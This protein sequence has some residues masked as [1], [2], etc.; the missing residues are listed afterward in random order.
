MR[1]TLKQI[2][3]ALKLLEESTKPLSEEE[4]AQKRHDGAKKIADAAEEKGGPAML[5]YHHFKVK[6]PYYREAAKG[7]FDFAK[8]EKEYKELCEKLHGSEYSKLTQTQFQE[9]VGRI[10]VLGELLINNE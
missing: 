5:T 9:L 2:D 4:F 3:E 1:Y 10:E 7:D 8:A 6:L